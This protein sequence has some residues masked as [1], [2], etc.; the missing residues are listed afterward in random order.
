KLYG[1]TSTT[2]LPF[3]TR[4]SLPTFAAFVAGAATAKKTDYP[5]IF[6]MPSLYLA[7]VETSKT[8]LFTGFGALPFTDP[9]TGLIYAR[10]R[11]LDPQTGSFLSADPAG[12]RDSSNLYLYAGGD[13]INRRDPT[14]LCGEQGEDP[15]GFFES[16]WKSVKKTVAEQ[17]DTAVT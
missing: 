14:G 16:A 12:Y 10:A 4:E 5:T 1:I 2:A 8:R 13:P 9:A 3:A 17:V 7:G 6:S 11:W 15:C